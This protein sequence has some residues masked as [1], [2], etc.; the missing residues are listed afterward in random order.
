LLLLQVLGRCISCGWSWHHWH[1][2]GHHWESRHC[3]CSELGS[4]SSR[5]G[6]RSISISSAVV[7]QK[8]LL[9]SHLLS[10]HC[11]ILLIHLLVKSHLLIDHLLLVYHRELLRISSTISV[12]ISGSCHWCHWHHSWHHTWHHSSEICLLLGSLSS[13]SSSSFFLSLF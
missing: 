8:L 9:H 2:W 6:L 12:L 7:I 1:L 11:L 10:E 5:C 13:L 3:I 4:S